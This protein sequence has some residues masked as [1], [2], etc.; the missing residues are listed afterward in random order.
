MNKKVYSVELFESIPE[1]ESGISAYW[2]IIHFDESK[3]GTSELALRNQAIRI[4]R[5]LRELDHRNP[6]GVECPYAVVETKM[7]DLDR[8]GDPPLAI[9][10][11]ISSD[12][13][14]RAPAGSHVRI[15]IPKAPAQPSLS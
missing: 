13:A 9:Y 11:G 7:V 14:L 5:N 1:V 10:D 6:C 2:F 8:L 12:W 3:N 4:A 15:S